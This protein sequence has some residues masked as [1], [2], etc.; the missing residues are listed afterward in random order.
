MMRGL[1]RRWLPALLAAALMPFAGCAN[2]SPPGLGPAE[3]D[4]AFDSSPLAIVAGDGARH[5]F[6]VW[7]AETDAQ[8][9]R[10]LMFVTDLPDDRG[11]LFAFGAREQPSMWMRNT[12]IP[13]DMLFLDADGRI[14]HIA[15]RTE[16]ESLDV[17]R[18]PHPARYVLELA[19]GVSEALGIGPGDRVEHRWISDRA[20]EQR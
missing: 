15:A 16:P 2:A 17:I 3:L 9:R 13:L 5:E 12:L 20:P 8:R 11:M 10:G 6:T 7:L 1:I 18:S 4:R 19:G 14:V